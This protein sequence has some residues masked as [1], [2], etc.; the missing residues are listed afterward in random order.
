MV[1]LAPVAGVNTDGATAVVNHT[2][3]A[4]SRFDQ[5]GNTITF[6]MNRITL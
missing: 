5:R 4:K 1:R 6:F 3:Y 2:I